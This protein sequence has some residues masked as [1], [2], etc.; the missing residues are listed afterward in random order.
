MNPWDPDRVRGSAD[1]L[2]ALH[3]AVPAAEEVDLSEE[4]VAERR[5]D[6]VRRMFPDHERGLTD[7]WDDGPRESAPTPH[8]VTGTA[9][10]LDVLAHLLGAE[11]IDDPPID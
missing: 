1:S 8:P 9:Q 4:V 6:R 5:A 11:V 2:R 3:A 10:A 7:A